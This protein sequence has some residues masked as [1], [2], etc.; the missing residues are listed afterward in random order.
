MIDISEYCYQPLPGDVVLVSRK[1]QGMRDLLPGNFISWRIS[2]RIQIE[3]GF[4]EN[5]VAA[6]E[7]N[8]NVIEAQFGGVVRAPLAQYVNLEKYAVTILR[9]QTLQL[10]ERHQIAVWLARRVGEQYDWR[11]IRRMWLKFEMLRRGLGAAINLQDEND[12]LWICSELVQAAYA[13]I[14]VDLGPGILCPGEYRKYIRRPDEPASPEKPF[15]IV[16]QT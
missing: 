4:P 15:A 10:Y 7:Y 14:G 1:W 11:L 6:V 3:S 9:H 16:F 5:H 8:Q 13:H 12:K 2:R